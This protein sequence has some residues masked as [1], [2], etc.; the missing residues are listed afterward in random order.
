MTIFQ[1]L[2][3]TFAVI[4]TV[5]LVLVAVL[6]YA[7]ARLTP[8]G[9]VNI[10]INDEKMLEVEPGNNLLTT[11]AQNKIYLPSACGG[12]GTCGLC[13]C[14]VLSGGGSILST[15]TVFFTRREQQS[16]WRLGCQV[17][18]RENMEIHIPAQVLGV[19]KWECEVISNRNVASFIK[20][21]VIQLPVG[22]NLD[23]RSGGYVQIDV[24]PVAVDFFKDI[25]IDEPFREDWSSLGIWELKMVNKEY[26]FRAYSMAN[27]PAEGNRIMLNVRIATPPWDRSRGA[28]MKVNPGICSS[29]IFSR[30][31]GDKVMISGP[32]GEFFLKETQAEKIFIGGGAG[33]APMRSHIFHLFKTLRTTDKVSFWY[34]ARSRREI[35]YEDEFLRIAKEFPNF[36][37]HI[38]L[39]E[40]KPQDNWTGH[41]GFIHKVLYDQYLKDHPDPEE[42]EF[43]ICGPPLMTSAVT[44]M[45]DNLGVP[46]DH[47]LFDDFGG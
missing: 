3:L 5:T 4:L 34:G 38:A 24:P 36:S 12:S 45:L 33:M 30:K 44:G 37:F 32:F 47:I 31:P 42:A 14:R 20:E 8:G 18:V 28:F 23:F 13:K 2:L 25:Q 9:N 15:E 10:K 35:F 6:I 40:P 1:F 43:Y 46:A 26:S 19:K 29:Y 17:K 39:S 7:K 21:F 11:L 41:T 22:E 27:H 16:Q